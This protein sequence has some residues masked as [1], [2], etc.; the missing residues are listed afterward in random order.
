MCYPVT[1]PGCGKTTWGGCGAHVDGVMKTVPESQK[2]T[3]EDNP[4]PPA[5]SG[6]F[7]TLFGR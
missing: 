6:F 3:C 2:C 7:S 4:A 1:C 5:K